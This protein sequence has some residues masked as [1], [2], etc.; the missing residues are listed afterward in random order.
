MLGRHSHLGEDEGEQ[1]AGILI[2]AHYKGALFHIACRIED[3]PQRS[4]VT[5]VTVMAGLT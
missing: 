2:G 5:Y 4:Q 1:A 3:G